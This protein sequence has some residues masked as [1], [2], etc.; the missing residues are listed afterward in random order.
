MNQIYHP[1][2]V[3]LRHWG[4]L[5]I[6]LLTPSIASTT[7]ASIIDLTTGPGSSGSINGGLFN[8]G[9]ASGGTGLIQPFLRIQASRTEEGYNS[10]SSSLPFDE[11]SGMW[12]HDLRLNEIPIIEVGG[13]SYFEFILDINEAGGGGNPFLSLDAI[14]IYTS[15]IGSQNTTDI[16]SL[17]TLRY[18]LD[19]I[20]DST[21]LL[22][23]SFNSGSG[24]TDMTAFIPIS[25]FAG[26]SPD[27]FVYFYSAFGELGK[28]G[29]RKYGS[30]NGFEEWAVQ[31]DANS[32]FIPAPGP[33]ALLLLASF[34]SKRRR[35]RR[36]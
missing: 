17:G 11:K 9:N 3:G 26:A 31:I 27:N 25:A 35:R 34:S 13:I 21:I 7:D 2:S 20:E 5:A 12:T 22:D 28:V 36:S 16:N 32:V 19:G 10:S 29:S 1:K 24:A 14:K 15:T 23:Y 6:I 4:V 8:F 18:D 33:L 30:T